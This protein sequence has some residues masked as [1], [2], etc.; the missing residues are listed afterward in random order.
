MVTNKIAS[1]I[2][3]KGI[4]FNHFVSTYQDFNGYL[5]SIDVRRCERTALEILVAFNANL[6]YYRDQILE[7]LQNEDEIQIK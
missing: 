5:A 2:R 3:D 6:K 4:E 7:E 1:A